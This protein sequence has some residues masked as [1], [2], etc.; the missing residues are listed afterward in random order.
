MPTPKK[1]KST[2]R[3]GPYLQESRAKKGLTQKDVSIALGYQT[4]QFVSEW[5]RGVRSPPSS[6]LRKLV[7]LYEISI[8]E[9]YEVLRAERVIHLEEVLK[10][11]LFESA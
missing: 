1:Y 7:D 5:E 2:K 10:R 6:A 8:D 3:L 4:A 9:F 11:E